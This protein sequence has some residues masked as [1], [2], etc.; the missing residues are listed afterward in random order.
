MSGK[1]IIQNFSMEEELID[2]KKIKYIQLL[3]S[4]TFGSHGKHL[5]VK[6]GTHIRKNI[7]RLDLSLIMLRVF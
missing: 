3:N 6:S 4:T 1:K 7:G 2:L 5:V